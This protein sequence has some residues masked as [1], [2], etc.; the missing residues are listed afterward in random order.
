MNKNKTINYN[1]LYNLVHIIIKH[2]NVIHPGIN[3]NFAQTQP[4]WRRKTAVIILSLSLCFPL[5]PE[6][7]KGEHRNIYLYIYQSCTF[8][9][10]K[11][12]VE[13]FH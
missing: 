1:G 3:N 10:M 5:M 2:R 4:S 9:H 8:M 7:I 11:R 13:G 6:F 12:K